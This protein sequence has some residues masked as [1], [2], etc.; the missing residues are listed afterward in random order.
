MKLKH[1]LLLLYAGAALFIMLVIGSFLATALKDIT[2]DRITRNYQQQ[3]KHIDF[4]LT[5]LIK[6]MEHDLEA[7][8]QNEFVRSRQDQNFT[9]FLEADEKTFEYDYGD[10]EQ[11]IIS[12]LN[13]YRTTHPYVHSVYM[14]RENGSFVR[15]HP[16]AR[17][18]RYDPR[19]R[20]WY[21]LAKENPGTVVRTPPFRSVTSPDISIGF[22]KAL[23]DD[24]DEFYGVVGTSITLNEL[25][26]YISNIKLDYNGY[27]ALAD[28]KGT[29]L[30]TP[31]QALLFTDL[32]KT[33]PQLFENLYTNIDGLAVFE[34]DGQEL[35]AFYYTSPLM[36]WK[37]AAIVPVTEINK[38]IWIFV[39]K[40]LAALFVSLLL[41]S[42]LTMMGL[43]HFVIKP[44][45]LLNDGTDHIKQTGELDYRIGIKSN[46]ELGSLGQSFNEMI[47]SIDQAESALK[48]SEA[49]LKKHR[50]HLEDLVEERTAELQ[51][52]QDALRKQKDFIET[53]ID[54]IPDSISII[55][56]DSGRIVDANEAFIAEVGKPRDQVFGQLCY[57]LTHSLSEMCAPPHHTCPMLKTKET[58]QKCTVEHTHQHADGHEVIVEVSTF[59]IKDEAGIFSQVVH[60]AH[61]ITERKQAERT[62]KESEERNRMLLERLPESVVVY[63]MEGRT[64]FVNSAFEKTFGWSRDAV[65]GKK[66]DFVPPELVAETQAAVKK[67]LA[68]GEES[69]FF[70]T[71]RLTKNGDTLDVQINTA[72]FHDSAGRKV[73]NIV[74]LNDITER[75][76]AEEAIKNS[77]QR[78]S[79]IINFLPDPTMVIDNDG[80]VVTWNQ[81][82]ENLS[83]A[84]TDDMVGKGNYEYAL[85]FYGERRPLLIDLAKDWDEEYEKKY[86]SVEKVGEKLIGESYHSNLGGKE[87]YL[88]ATAGLIYDTAGE[89]AGAIE[90]VRDITEKK[91]ADDIIRENEER[92]SNILKTTSEGFWLIDT[93]DIT[94]DINEAMCEILQRPREEVVGSSISQYLDEENVKTVHRQEV[95]RGEDEKGLY[96]VSINRADG[97]IVPCLVNAAPLFDADGNKI[98]SFGMFTD[99]TER[100]QME[101]ELIDA[102]HTAI[103]AN[104][105]KGDFLAN[106]SHEIRTP[107]NAVIGMTHLALKTELTSKQQDYLHKIQSSANSLLGIINDILDF[108]KIEAGKM[109]MES[110]NFTLDDVL[111]NL[112]NLISVKAQEK[113]DLEVLFATDQNVPHFLVG[114]P[115]RLGQVLINL[116]NNA[117]KF[118]DTGEIVVST[119]LLHQTE[120]K[121]TLQFSVSDTGIGL[122]EEQ[123]GKLFQS[124]TQADTSTTRKYGGTG[125]G[126]TISKRLVEMMGGEIWVESEPGQGSSFIFTASFGPGQEDMKKRFTPTRD[127]RGMKVLVVDDNPTSREI[128]RDM[129]ESF[130]FE[131]A[132]AASG[133]E[134][135]AEIEKADK[136]QPFE[137]VIMD[138]KMPG[139]DGIEA[140]RRIKENSRLSHVPN[141]VMVTAY[142]REEVLQKSQKIGLDGFLLKPVKPSVLFDTVMQACGEDVSAASPLDRQ[143]DDAAAFEQ[144]RGARILLAE[145]NEINQQV[146]KEILEGAGLIVSLADDGQQA[147]NMLKENSYDVV[148]MD[149]Q[150][151]VMDGYAATKAIRKDDRF[152]ELPIIAMTAHAMAGDEE[153]SL[154]AGMN[155]HVT[156]PIDP[157]QL[158]GALQKWIKPPDERAPTEPTTEAAP[159][160]AAGEPKP[161]APELPDTLPGFELAEGLNRLQGNQKLY[162]KLLLDFGVKYTTVAAEIKEAVTAGD[163]DAA[164]GLVH[165]IKGLAGNLAATKLQAAAANFEKLIK[166]DPKPSPSQQ[167][168]DGKFSILE[169]AINR[170]LQAVQS[171]GP[172]PE[173]APAT[174]SKDAMAAITPQ[175]AKEAA[176]LL[177]EPVEMGDVTQIKTIAEALKLK[178][179]AFEAFSA[180]CIQLAD[181]FDFEGIA[182][183]VAKLEK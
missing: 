82:M 117:V 56:I 97:S 73:G 31:K 16:R 150:M 176:D 110:V 133:Q 51:E 41:L 131:V 143:Q 40:I 149:I 34:R 88:H 32:K 19:V 38:V 161:D 178:S 80:T 10:I 126:L 140:S 33:D 165:N 166:G 99:I 169:A 108:S 137:M 116:A 68:D 4:G 30:A 104:K 70:E 66:I 93:E 54:S 85:P 89:V 127:L 144:I 163:F 125:L 8:A 59:P 79:Q 115:L 96:E 138:W 35:Y 145:D 123:A 118:T 174:P 50:D 23:V 172:A 177:K 6:G 52:K 27:V 102:K 173:Q 1:K 151:P 164:H 57:E 5:R 112:G 20:P 92:L 182:K 29:V 15:S 62:L 65:L 135:I 46:D 21:K 180:Q 49:E 139:M 168:L 111:D 9:S 146:A 120:E 18:T 3:L 162:R 122:T 175:L 105:A 44:L 48:K 17:P 171:L 25:T 43:Q 12:I 42:I 14:G 58:G 72:P 98:G 53:V 87:T 107:M 26:Q 148:L 75:K 36:E 136:N 128:L 86:L 101:D 22:V 183:L 74:I 7:I 84:K 155:G 94:L 156:K 13:G 152:K 2:I 170:A 76:K 55:E 129:L 147:V 106:M 179:S 167:Q 154:Q 109:D 90:S 160:A 100:K 61:D 153:K 28:E 67:L 78:L 159:S 37:M 103:E 81:A 121:V 39:L 124:F 119:K 45:K 91:K 83:G 114:D 24:A 47:G 181:D 95:K 132:L 158:F 69:V 64:I 77:E 63:D 157:D 141:I 60:V 71:K 130:S 134:G 142:G 113:E 11:R